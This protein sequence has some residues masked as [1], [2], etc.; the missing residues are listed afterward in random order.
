MVC[1]SNRHRLGARAAFVL[2]LSAALFWSV[3]AQRGRRGESFDANQS[4]GASW[5]VTSRNWAGYVALTRGVSAISA[6][7]IVPQV[8]ATSQDRSSATWIGIGGA[9]T[10]DLIQAGTA[11][12]SV[13]GHEVY[14]V[15][16]ETLPARPHRFQID[17]L[18]GDQIQVSMQSLGSNMWSIQATD[19]SDGEQDSVQ[20][21]Y[22]S[23]LSSADWVEEAPA[24]LRGR[25][26]PLADFGSVHFSD[27]TAT[28]NGAQIGL[29][30]AVQVTMTD[31]HQDMV[32]VAQTDANAFDAVYTAGQN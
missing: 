24:D 15:W 12:D 6:S 13:G 1:L 21:S 22:R 9:T 7:W 10:D 18:P 3:P 8:S 16:Y 5:S 20:T 23:T 19:L 4:T 11:Q 28:A 31:G 2:A 27:A 14:E 25:V 30:D 26:K 17:V 29:A 32:Q